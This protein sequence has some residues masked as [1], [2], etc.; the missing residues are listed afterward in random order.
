MSELDYIGC[1]KRKRGEGVLKFKG[2]CDQGYPVEFNGS[3]QENVRALLEIGQME[4]GLCDPMP[5]WSFQL[6]VHRHPLLHVFL[7]VVEE[8]IELSL[9]RGC[10]HCQYIGWGDHLICNKKYHFLLPSKD[11]VSACL[12]YEGSSAG[13]NVTASNSIASKSNLIDLQGHTMH[14]VFHSNG[15]GHL[16]CINGEET[17]SDLAGFQIMD[18]WDRLCTGLRA[19]EVS[20][21]DLSQ[22]QGMDLRLLHSMAYGKPWF[23]QWGYKFGR[24]SFG[25]TEP[26]YRSAIEALQNTPLGLFA[27]HLGN[28]TNEILTIL[29]RYQML[30]GHI[31]VTLGD[32]FHFMLEL[33]SKLPK[34][35]NTESSHPGMLVD[36][37]CRWSAKRIEMAIRVIIEALQRAEF[38]W[39]SR[40]E[41]RDAAR[42]YIGDTGL[43]D[44]VLKSLGNHI[45]GKYLVRR[46]LNPVTK[47][48][49]YCLED[50]SH[51]FPRR[52]GYSRLI[53]TPDSKL[54]P[55]YKITWAQLMKDLLR[56]YKLILKENNAMSSTGILA[57][58]PIASRIILDTKLFIKDYSEESTSILDK[59]VLH[60]SIVLT[61]NTDRGSTNKA[62]ITPYEFFMLRNTTTFDEL[63]LEVERKFRDLYWGMRNFVAE[64]LANLDAKGSDLVF[65]LIKAGTK[66]V[67]EGKISGESADIC[68]MMFESF[69]SN[70]LVVDCICGTKIDD[71]ER[72]VSCDICEVRQHTRCVHVSNIEEIPTIFLCNSCEQDI[73]HFPSLP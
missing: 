49:E 7:F 27:H 28:E 60:C 30:S 61:S 69:E 32:M 5:I 25:V 18:F 3:F 41:V 64:S 46:C 10:K 70:A 36:T 67:F 11:T 8:P 2:F 6:E 33:K 37:S 13:I 40:Q 62:M 14:G 35:S 38:R 31:L 71:G 9:T 59:S 16:L 55:R 23:G 53:S 72:M 42:A 19:R 20:L 12:S 54:K 21:R 57:S 68:C 17:G 56:L 43:L 39:I 34:E 63:K 45:V 73:L 15:F 58:I 29:S 47:V 44:F 48:L 1:K 66:I 4:T 51:A 65:K 50:I 22:K 24:G 52:D 26:M